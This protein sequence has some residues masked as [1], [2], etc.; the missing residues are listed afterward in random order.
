M[1]FSKRSVIYCIALKWK[2]INFICGLTLHTLLY[3]SPF[4]KTPQLVFSAP[5]LTGMLPNFRYLLTTK[6]NCLF[7]SYLFCY[8]HT[9]LTLPLTDLGKP[10]REK[11]CSYLEIVQRE[12][13]FPRGGGEGVDPNPK[14]LR[15]F[16]CFNLNIM[17]FFS[18][19]F[20]AFFFLNF[21][22]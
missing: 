6:F 13:V 11:I 16:F 1:S 8:W 19:T 20:S 7:L 5:R 4:H 9:L 14:L 21:F 10:D 2:R 12:G 17:S 15:N 22:C 3:S 18:S